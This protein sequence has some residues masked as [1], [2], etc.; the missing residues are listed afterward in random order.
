MTPGELLEDALGKSWR[1]PKRRERAL[2]KLDERA[3]A[4]FLLRAEDLLNNLAQ[5]PAKSRQEG[6]IW[7]YLAPNPGQEHRWL[8]AAML[9]DHL[10]LNRPDWIHG[11]PM[12][13]QAH[14]TLAADLAGIEPPAARSAKLTTLPGWAR[15]PS[16]PSEEL[17]ELRNELTAETTQNL[18]HEREAFRQ[19]LPKRVKAYVRLLAAVVDP[20]AAGRVSFIEAWDPSWEIVVHQ[21]SQR[22]DDWGKNEFGLKL[23]E[24]RSEGMEESPGFRDPVRETVSFFEARQRVEHPHLGFVPSAPGVEKTAKLFLSYWRR[25]SFGFPIVADVAGDPIERATSAEEMRPA[26]FDQIVLPALPRLAAVDPVSMWQA[27][28]DSDVSE[29]RREMNPVLW[30][31][32]A[33]GTVEESAR[34]IAEAQRDLATR[35]K[36]ARSA[37]EKRAAAD[38][39]DAVWDLG[40]VVIGI[41]IGL[42]ITP[43]VGAIAAPLAGWGIRTA[44]KARRV[45]PDAPARTEPSLFTL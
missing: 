36:E 26:L 14:R 25:L 39:K 24:L 10:V 40:T 35:A 44:L 12:T 11:S 32:M 21:I 22:Y 18:A 28:E 45:E 16:L 34:R 37:L 30:H 1:S 3:L 15:D 33:A 29:F 43:P 5:A 2:A 6:E 41:A 9:A 17:T 7:A 38:R 4:G 31:I 19:R 8:T 13:L 42:F 20:V 23:E 27:I